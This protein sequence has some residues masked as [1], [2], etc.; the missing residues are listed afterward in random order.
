[1]TNNLS[2]FMNILYLSCHS[3]LEYD[4]VKLFTEL[5]HNV[6][7][8]QG[9]YHN[10]NMPTDPKRPEIVGPM[11]QQLMDVALQCSKDDIHQELI[12]WADVIYVMHIDR[13]ILN[14]WPKIKQKI[15]IWRTIGQSVP[16]IEG[17]LALFRTEGL[18]VVRYSP[19]EEGI[20][21]YIGSDAIIRF[22]KDPNEFGSWYGSS[23]GVMTVSQ[24]MKQRGKFCGYETWNE[25]TSG[26]Q[27]TIYGPGNDELDYWGGC[28]SYQDL[29]SAY[30]LH[31]VYF[32]TGTYPA[33]YT[34]N[35]IEAL[36]TGIPIVAVGHSLWNVGAYDIQA[37]EVPE[38]LDKY[39]SEDIAE[40]RGFVE[41]L[42][43]DRDLAE[44]TGR[45]GREKAIELFG[46]ETIKTQ[47]QSFFDSL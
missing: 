16:Q 15:V 44:E 14:N 35:F 29:I 5:G 28:L 21:G 43:K 19:K 24:S 34:L 26:L 3:V 8:L 18:R 23:G 36:M 31:G 22:Y 38:I 7:S 2:G 41:A 40:L 46:K 45:K 20:K 47:W 1:M 9:A 42:L 37:Y 39:V 11:H 4:E 13:W 25:V 27:R 17:R 12:D 33:A 6:F 30:R 10:P 32:Y